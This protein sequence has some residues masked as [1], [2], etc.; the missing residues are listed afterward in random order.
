MFTKE[1]MEQGDYTS[2]DVEVIKKF[3]R[4]LYIDPDNLKQSEEN[5]IMVMKQSADVLCAELETYKGRTD[6]KS[7]MATSPSIFSFKG[8]FLVPLVYA[9]FVINGI[10]RI[11][12]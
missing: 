5:V 1:Q 9:R 7:F 2:S 3:R 6:R 8:S 10:T 4:V 11:K 12:E